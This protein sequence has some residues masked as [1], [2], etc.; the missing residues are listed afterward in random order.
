MGVVHSLKGDSGIIAVKIAVLHEI[1][2]DIDNLDMIEHVCPRDK[3]R[4]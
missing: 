3:G 4:G 2:D 1:L